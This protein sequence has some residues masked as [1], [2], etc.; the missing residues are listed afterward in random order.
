MDI[1]QLEAYLNK[2]LRGSHAHNKVTICQSCDE[3]LDRGVSHISSTRVQY[4][5]EVVSGV[6][7]ELAGLGAEAGC[8]LVLADK[9]SRALHHT[10]CFI[11]AQWRFK[12]ETACS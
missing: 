9:D 8:T 1:R 12:E 5:G 7:R 10:N 2:L 4:L 6:D 3:V 11:I